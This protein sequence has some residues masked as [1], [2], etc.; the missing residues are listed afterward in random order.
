MSE[1]VEVEK[2]KN[3]L[4]KIWTFSKFRDREKVQE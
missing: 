1:V 3:R 2:S 4:K